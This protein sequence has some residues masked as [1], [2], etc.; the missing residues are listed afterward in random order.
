MTRNCRK[1]EAAG[2]RKFLHGAGLCLLL[3]IVSQVVAPSQTTG[4]T[5][6]GTVLDPTGAVVN[7]ATVQVVNDA[8]NIL[9]TE[10]QAAPVSSTSPT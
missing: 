9:Q 10:K 6:T 1:I 3:L 5:I 4:G 2:L 8:T 7:G